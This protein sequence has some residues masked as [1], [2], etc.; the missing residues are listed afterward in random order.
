MIFKTIRDK[1]PGG[2]EY[3]HRPLDLAIVDD[4]NNYMKVSTPLGERY[5]KIW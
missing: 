3:T 5:N 4:G 1:T 2:L